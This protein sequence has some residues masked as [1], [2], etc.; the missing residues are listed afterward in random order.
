MKQNN[1]RKKI[2]IFTTDKDKNL[3]E[4]YVK[5]LKKSSG[6]TESH[7]LTMMLVR[8]VEQNLGEIPCKCCD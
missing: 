4:N 1:S 2:L 5:E 3:V 7:I 6:R 8:A